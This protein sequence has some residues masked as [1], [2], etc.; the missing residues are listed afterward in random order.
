[1]AY[2]D[3]AQR[4]R[5][6]QAR[7][8][9][10]KEEQEAAKERTQQRAIE[11][12]KSTG[13]LVDGKSVT[14]EQYLEDKRAGGPEGRALARKALEE[15]TPKEQITADPE[16]FGFV[17]PVEEE[18]PAVEGVQ[19]VEEG[20]EQVGEEVPAGTRAI[21][22]EEL[23]AGL[24]QE[25]IDAGLTLQS[26]GG[27]TPITAGDILSVTG[28]AGVA[29]GLG[30]AAF[31]FATSKAQTFLVHRSL[32]TGAEKALATYAKTPMGIASRTALFAAEKD[33]LKNAV[34]G[35]AI[36]Q[37][38]SHL[39]NTAATTSFLGK[40]W[41]SVGNM[42]VG[43]VAAIG[44]GIVLTESIIS[45]SV[46]ESQQALN[47]LGQITS[48]IVGDSTSGVGDP[49]KGLEE[50][51]YIIDNL[52][53]LEKEMKEGVIRETTLRINGKIVDLNA[54][55][56]DQLATA[57]EGKREIQAFMVSGQFPELS[58]F[59]INEVIREL[60]AD[61][62]IEP[63]DLTKAR[64]ETVGISGISGVLG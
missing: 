25:D 27:V 13:F 38:G 29:S 12:G 30:R 58:D 24:V 44:G 26:V 32:T 46:D 17:Q 55:I 16:K 33:A 36:V 41:Q 64:R 61:E 62:I 18:V 49:K 11:A 40:L 22:Q 4:F 21:T 54:D 45:G 6:K 8:K 39:K 2:S 63:V 47:T 53:R 35:K 60:E 50:M 51:D 57:Y 23:D 1:M 15:P 43:Q 34:T 52:L 3:P 20:V 7:A 19:P 42:G 56:Y 59:E 5:D 37:A 28:A 48:T 9:K 14:K 31:K 10:K